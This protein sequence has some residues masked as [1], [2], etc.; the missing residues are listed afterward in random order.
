MVQLLRGID[1]TNNPIGERLGEDYVSASGIWN[2]FIVRISYV[3]DVEPSLS[4][5]NV[6]LNIFG[7]LATYFLIFDDDVSD[8]YVKRGKQTMLKKVHNAKILLETRTKRKLKQSMVTWHKAYEEQ[9]SR[10]NAITKT[11]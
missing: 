4:K 8:E 9:L 5:L 1:L 7:P 2:P 11:V 10:Q 6:R 3:D